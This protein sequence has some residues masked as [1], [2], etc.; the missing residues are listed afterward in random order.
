MDNKVIPYPDFP[1]LYPKQ[2]DAFYSDKRIM[3]TEASTKAG[4]S[5]GALVWLFEQGWKGGK[6]R[7]YGW[8]APINKSAV[9]IGYRGMK[10]FLIQWDEKQKFW[11]EVVSKQR[12]EVGDGSG[13]PHCMFNFFGSEDE[14]NVYGYE[15]WAAVVDEGSRCKRES[16]HA[17]FTTMTFTKG[18]IRVIGNVKNKAVWMYELGEK[19][20][21]GSKLYGY[22]KITAIDA[23]EAGVLDPEAIEAARETLPDAIFERD[24]MAVPHDD[25]RAFFRSQAIEKQRELFAKEPTRKRLDHLTGKFVDDPGGNWYC[26]FDGDQPY[27]KTNYILGGDIS[28]GVA[29]S[30]SVLGAMDKE[31]G[32]VVAEYVDP[33]ISPEDF[34]EETI[35]AGKG[36]FAGQHGSALVCWEANGPGEGWFRHF[37]RA[38]YSNLYYQHREGTRG[39]RKSR[40]YGWHS[41]RP[42]KIDRLGDLRAALVDT[43]RHRRR[44]TI[45]SDAGLD[46]MGRY[47]YMDDG[48]VGPDTVCDMISGARASHGDRVIAYMLCL[49]ASSDAWK[50]MKQKTKA[51][52]GTFGDR[53][54]MG[55]YIDLD[56]YDQKAAV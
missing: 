32:D 54:D 5:V 52:P 37:L 18:P 33:H 43:P 1:E 41:S 42:L 3:I 53:F 14:D 26:W 20:R 2:Y 23:M 15:N 45:H 35:R 6:G 11:G 21:K 38:G 46:E 36:P 40:K 39:E 25:A 4:K 51:K 16:W 55:R 44:I 13:S 47:I 27:Q 8:M 48:S 10:E 31:N 28:A 56:E 50:Y 29:S 34:A 12:I 7:S 19:A 24:Y 49:M 9:E 30:N 17:L 22:Q